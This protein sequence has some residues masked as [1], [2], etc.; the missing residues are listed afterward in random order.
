[1]D[2]LKPCPFC[3]REAVLYVHDGGVCV[4]CTN[5]R[6]KSVSRYD[7]LEFSKPT[8]A[9]KTVVEAWNRRADNEA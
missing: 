4:I 2:E 1:M 6:A 3:G 5:C 9:V 7:S 8:N